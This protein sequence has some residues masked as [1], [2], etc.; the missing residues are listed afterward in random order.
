MVL[1][2]ILP[3]LQLIFLDNI[4]QENMFQDIIERKTQLSRL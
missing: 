3:L 2:E 4:G 1:V